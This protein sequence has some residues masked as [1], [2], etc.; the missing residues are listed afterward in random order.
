MATWPAKTDYA[1]GNV[2][3]AAQMNDIGGELND[4]YTVAGTAA[5]VNK[6]INGDFG[7][8]QRG[9]SYTSNTYGVYGGADR[10]KVSSLGGTSTVSQQ[11]FTAGTA[12]VAGYEGTYFCRIATA[13]ASMTYYDIGQ[14]IESVRTFAGQTVTVS[15]WAKA[16]VATTV[17][18]NVR[19][20]FGTGGSTAI[21]NL[22]SSF[23]LS[24][25][26]VR[27]T[28]TVAVPSITGKTIGTND[29]LGIYLQYVSGTINSITVDT[30][31]WQVEAG[32][33]ASP[34]QTASGTKQG[35]LALCQRYLPATSP[36]D[37]IGYAYNNNATI[38]SF[39]YPVT[40]RVAPTGVTT[41][42]SFNGYSGNTAYSTTLSFNSAGIYS[43][44]LTGS[45][46]TIVIGSGSRIT[47][48][49]AGTILWTGCEL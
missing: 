6:I 21:N 49:A 9:T 8:W 29:N 33:I 28:Q 26:W 12:P 48:N 42:G 20:D 41:S 10:F 45:G 37:V 2:L 5:G 4:L 38:Y 39:V 17:Q 30:W 3:T 15:F 13:A 34:F 35:E 16:S 23:A 27:Y 31:G 47:Q 18:V 14:A 24:T 1:T 40:P 36:N 43:G 44:S 32:S 11:T 19:Q 7:I 22:T 25:S 46:V